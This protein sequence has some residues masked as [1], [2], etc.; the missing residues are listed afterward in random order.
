VK[1]RKSTKVWLAILA[2]GVL[3]VLVDHVGAGNVLGGA[4]IPFWLAALAAC[5]IL[6]VRGAAALF[7]AIIH[8]L[9]LRLAFSYFLIGIVPI[10]L[11]A[12][13]LALV[14][15]IA[16]SQ[17]IA[18][19]ALREAEALAETAG[20]GSRG[21]VTARVAG[22]KVV[23]TNAPWLPIGA[24]A[25]WVSQLDVPRAVLA[26]QEV[27]MARAETERTGTRVV[28]VPLDTERLQAIAR[29]TG[30]LVRLEAGTSRSRRG[31]SEVSAPR[32]A[33]KRRDRDAEAHVNIDLGQGRKKTWIRPPG[34]APAA[35]SLLGGEWVAG[36]RLEPAV[37]SYPEIESPVAIFLAR[38]SPRIFVRQLFRQ[39]TP[40]V[41]GVLLAIIAAVAGSLFFV[42]LVA[43]VIAFVLVGS[44]ARNVNR[45]TRAAQAIGRGDLS[46]RVNSR[47]RDQIGDLARSFDGMAASIQRLLVETAKK[48]KI[49]AELS[50]A[51]AIQRS[52]LPESGGSWPGF[53]VVSHFEPVAEVGGDFYDVLRIA[54]G[55]TAVILG[56]VSGH[57]LP[58]GLLASAAK[59]SI[60]TLIEMGTS[61]PE[62]CAKLA[63]RAVRAS[64]RRSF[65][66]LAL[67]SYDASRRAG[68]LTNAGHPAPYRLSAGRVDRLPLPAFPIGLLA[69]G[70]FPSKEI[71]FAPGDLLV[72]FTDGIVE[73]TD[74][75]G[76]PF[77][78]ERLEWLLEKEAAK[79]AEELLASILSAV[80]AH[81]GRAEME[82]DRT[83]VLLAFA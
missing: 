23:E 74:E 42:Y 63:A 59:A 17:V 80:A 46:V 70:V 6:G 5:A 45:L 26:G 10:P 31:S 44:I 15:Y 35:A 37:A 66:T 60:T 77:G 65:L 18:T 81:V 49:D 53:H 67:F 61:G 57:G 29:R 33:D 14:G 71:S 68:T 54:D 78:Y 16:T 83:L 30:Y 8:R 4:V 62:I 76:D 36:F 2:A 24:P 3:G 20:P 22:G 13:L 73:A 25:A 39:G 27:W 11:L 9:T 69:Q 19:R 47:S 7:R 75:A 79:T 1:L 82:D 41:G 28:L 64:N 55:R 34:E 43:L 50:V 52:L 58:T 72:L 40:E 56:D 48:E 38:T 51:R 12:L 21:V 32:S